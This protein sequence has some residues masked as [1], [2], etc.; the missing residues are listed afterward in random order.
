[1]AQTTS[2]VAQLCIR[3]LLRKTQEREEE[4]K[5]KKQEMQVDKEI[6]QQHEVERNQTPVHTT[7]GEAFILNT[8]AQAASSLH[9][10]E[11]PKTELK[12]RSTTATYMTKEQKSGKKISKNP[13]STNVDQQSEDMNQKIV[14]AQSQS[15]WTVV[16]ECISGC[17]ESRADEKTDNESRE[18]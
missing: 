12:S 7:E 8:E 5:R 10:S 14:T 2:A 6:R 18:M 4:R 13:E 11:E 3:E 16:L 9:P 17:D 15:G 1:M